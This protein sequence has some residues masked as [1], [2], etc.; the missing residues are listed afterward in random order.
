MKNLTP[1]Q[2]NAIFEKIKNKSTGG[3]N[4]KPMTPHEPSMVHPKLIAPITPPAP[5]IPPNPGASGMPPMN[6]SGQVNPNMIGNPKA[7][8]FARMKKMLGI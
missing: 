5:Q 1:A 3:I 2:K 6:P 7:Q 4:P 8:R